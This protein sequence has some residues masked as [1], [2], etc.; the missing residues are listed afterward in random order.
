[1]SLI[2]TICVLECVIIGGMREMLKAV[3]FDMDG[4]LVDSEPMHKEA[5]KR[6][7]MGLGYEFDDEYYEQFIGTTNPYMWKCIREKYGI[8]E[9][10]PYLNSLVADMKSELIR[11]N[12][13]RKID[14]VYELVKDLKEHGLI[15]VVASSSP[16]DYIEQVIDGVGISQFFDY[17]VS[18]E[19]VPNPKPAPDIFL[20][21]AKR[22]NVCND[23]CIIFE[24]SYNGQRAAYNAGIPVIGYINPGSG[25]QDLSLC[26]M[27]FEGYDE[28]DYQFVYEVY[29]RHFGYPVQ[30]CE[31]ERT[32]VREITVDDVPA[33]YRIYKGNVTKYIEPLYSNIK[34]EIEFTKSYIENQYKFFGYGMWV[35][36]LK[37]TGKVIG[38][39]G[40]ENRDVCGENQVELGY[41]IAE[42]YQNNNIATEVIT[43][44]INYA[45]KR[46]YIENLN[47][48]TDPR[49]EASMRIA[50]KLGFECKGETTDS[51][52]E[53]YMWFSKNII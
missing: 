6:V 13:Y 2:I 28:L 16:R 5:V 4:V 40:L 1:M 38:R 41:V 43:D 11:E 15:L 23:E 32:I 52:G 35:V 31:T 18:G 8:V 39:A 44:I 19:E 53:H 29:C 47:I 30:I 21:A 10:V 26:D 9:E 20:E 27:L 12:G 14:G 46:L 50:N 42:A 33:L 24:D 3:L 48:F 45:A 49:N 25:K 17:I 37:E 22:A 34:D 7:L 51:N 36:V